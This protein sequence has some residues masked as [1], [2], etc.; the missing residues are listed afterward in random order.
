M[1]ATQVSTI[2]ERIAT[3]GDAYGSNRLGS[4]EALIDLSRDLIATLEISSEFLQRS[5]WAEPGLSTHC[6]IAVEVK[7]FQHLRD[8]GKMVLPLSALAEQTGVTLL[9]L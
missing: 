1:A 8:A 7:L 5:F 2:L 9:F 4:R 6:K 3:T